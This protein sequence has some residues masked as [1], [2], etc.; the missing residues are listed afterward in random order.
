MAD[1]DVPAAPPGPNPPARR[2]II[3]LRQSPDWTALTAGARHDADDFDRLIGRPPGSTSDLMALWNEWSPVGFYEVRARIKQITLANLAQVREAR[4][5]SFAALEPPF[6]PEALYLF[7]D[8]DDW[9]APH[10]A[11][12]LLD[13]GLRVDGC[14]WTSVRF[15]GTVLR[16]AA[17]SFC[18]TNNYAIHGGFLAAAPERARQ[19]AQHTWADE[20]LRQ[21]G[22][23]KETLDLPLSITNKHPCS[24]VTLERIKAEGQSL[25]DAIERYRGFLAADP[26][27]LDAL[28]IA[29]A[30]EPM[31][32][33]SRFFV[34]LQR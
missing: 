20:A 7:T 8:D 11:T 10:L 3:I 27:S 18:Y 16:R 21:P 29:W 15:D 6:D 13:R 33:V 25:A 26:G 4:L 9:F 17:D 34:R 32:D 1:N 30:L 5:S 24:R 31:S 28:G 23:V 12:T 2:A 14:V 22:V 19:V